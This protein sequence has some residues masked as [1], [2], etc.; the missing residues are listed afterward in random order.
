MYDENYILAEVGTFAD[1]K[2]TASFQLHKERRDATF[3]PLGDGVERFVRRG[4]RDVVDTGDADDL[5]RLERAGVPHNHPVYRAEGEFKLALLSIDYGAG[6]ADIVNRLGTAAGEVAMELQRSPDDAQFHGERIASLVTRL[7]RSGSRD[8]VGTVADALYN[9][10]RFWSM[11]QD[12]IGEEVAKAQSN[13]RNRYDFQSVEHRGT[14]AWGSPPYRAFYNEF[15]EV[16]ADQAPF[17]AEA[18][19]EWKYLTQLEAKERARAVHS[20]WVGI[21]TDLGPVD[22]WDL[23]DLAVD[24]GVL[25]KRYSEVASE[26]E[27]I[28]GRTWIP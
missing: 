15:C 17:M 27:V 28:G 13:L 5:A 22:V 4:G 14:W 2:G 6:C 23:M 12:W 19:R 24:R 10:A 18:I 16:L 26:M 21:A 11:A 20:L 9:E 7:N 8:W 1:G 3:S 25:D